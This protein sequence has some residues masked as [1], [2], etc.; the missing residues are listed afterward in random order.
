MAKSMLMMSKQA[1]DIDGSVKQKAYTF[2]DKLTTDDTSPGLHIE[3]IAHTADKRVRTGRVDDK[4]RAVLFKLDA[5][6]PV[7]VL[8]GIWMHDEAIAKAKT[9]K[10]SLNPVNGVVE[11]IKAEALIEP[12]PGYSAPIK[13]YSAAAESPTA[14]PISPKESPEEIPEVAD[15]SVEAI[16]SE[17][18]G[19]AVDDSPIGAPLPQPAAPLLTVS[20]AELVSLGIDPELAAHA[21][22]ITDDA[23]FTSALEG[24]PTWQSEALLALATGSSIDQ[25]TDELELSTAPREV[26][27]DDDQ[28]LID[29]FDEPASM[30]EF[31][32]IEGSDELRRVIE[33]GDFGAWRVFLHPVQ[34]AWVSRNWNGAFRL[35]GGAGTG[36]TVVAVHRARRLSREDLGRRIVLTTF[37]RNLADELQSSLGRLD[38]DLPTTSDLGASGIY[39]SGI[40]A[41]ASTIV[42][43][44]GKGISDAAEQV[45]GAAR[46][47]L[48]ERMSNGLWSR[49]VRETVDLPSQAAS[50]RFLESE[51]QMVVLPNLITTE[52]EYLKVRRPG[53]GVRLNKTA[54][55]AVWRAIQRYRDE[56]SVAGCTDFAERAAIA[57]C[58][59]DQVADAHPGTGAEVM[60]NQ[61][62]RSG[63]SALPT[64]EVG[65]V[66]DHV[67]VDEGQD[68]QPAHWMLIR[69][70]VAE[71]PN[72]I[73]IAEDAHQRIYGQRLV[74]SHF[75]IKTQGRSR[76]LTL[77]YRTT[78][79]NLKWAT[80]IL[81]GAKYQNLDG[82]DD[83]VDG[84]R[85]ARRGPKP[86]VRACAGLVEELDVAADTLRA[87]TA[88]DQ[89][90]SGALAVLVRDRYQRDRVVAGLSERGV[91]ARAVDRGTVTGSG[92]VVMTMHRA[93]GMEFTKVILFDVSATSIPAG[94]RNFDYSPEDKADAE[95]RERALLYVAASRA[96]MSWSSSGRRFMV[97]AHC[98]PIVSPQ[99]IRVHT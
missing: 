46:S 87:W 60:T 13:G 11:I 2:L 71:A 8:Y 95:L 33:E 83:A 26:A 45:L 62:R 77:N 96:V 44:A 81:S 42:R 75:G 90:G 53:R 5:E 56:E 35:A 94:L 98:Y 41:L 86:T 91:T 21:V 84:Y 57:A 70:L 49:V 31:A 76:K 18:E 20:A 52:A 48:S 51:Y 3:P 29:A 73:L 63:E 24:A 32:R 88:E 80:A 16:A 37:T 89:A 72:D 47:D 40:D 69:A 93:K 19:I 43:A 97:P 78:A 12:E 7:Y 28:A 22:T 1:N 61:P 10:I 92:P 34:R 27:A 55:Q 79:E 64:N 66:A 74:L 59:L 39:V 30:M 85:S 6:T 54:R 99:S 65:R 17:A 25:V 4:Y 82:E 38:P 67:L 23:E 50:A 36:K 15:A 68:L 14:S 58:Y 9:A